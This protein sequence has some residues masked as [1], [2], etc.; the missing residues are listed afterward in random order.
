MVY[1]VVSRT[2]RAT[3][4]IFFFFNFG[5]L[6]QGFSVALAPVRAL[7]LIDQAGLELTEIRVPGI[8]GVHHQC[9]ARNTVLRRKKKA[10]V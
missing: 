3:Y 9:P 4:R 6:K 1:R 10:L 5:F 8:K 2:A 7:A